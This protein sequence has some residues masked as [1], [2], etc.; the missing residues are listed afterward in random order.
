MTDDRDLADVLRGL[1]LVGL[2]R[3]TAGRLAASGRAR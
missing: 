1:R 3:L 2:P